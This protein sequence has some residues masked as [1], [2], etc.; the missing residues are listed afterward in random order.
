MSC[1]LVLLLIAISWLVTCGLV[2][3]VGL[4]FGLT[5]TWLTGTG[6]WFLIMLLRSIFK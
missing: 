5:F 1:L 2:Y 4:C 3:V 6:V